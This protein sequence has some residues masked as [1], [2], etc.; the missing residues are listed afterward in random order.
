MVGRPTG[1]TYHL[2]R[3]RIQCLLLMLLKGASMPVLILLVVVQCQVC[4]LPEQTKQKDSL[5]IAQGFYV[6]LMERSRSG[7]EINRKKRFKVLYAPQ[8]NFGS[9]VG[10]NQAPR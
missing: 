10:I 4:K 9:A 5:R 7:Y 2:T 6:W 3:K 8:L 1:F